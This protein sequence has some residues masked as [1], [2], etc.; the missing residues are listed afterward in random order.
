M[1]KR[2]LEH[3]DILNKFVQNR[4]RQNTED[5]LIMTFDFVDPSDSIDSERLL[6]IRAWQTQT[7]CLDKCLDKGLLG[8]SF[9]NS[10]RD[11]DETKTLDTGP[12]T[13][14]DIGIVCVILYIISKS[15]VL[16]HEYIIE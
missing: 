7:T 15:Y 2:T 1:F 16:T 10:D 8:T 9:I 13:D 4:I 5:F 14:S 6:L 11:K 12:D 3:L